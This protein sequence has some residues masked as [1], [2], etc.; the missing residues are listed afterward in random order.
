MN[1]G[2]EEVTEQRKEI[3][4]S[5]NVEYTKMHNK[6][7]KYVNCPKKTLK[8]SREF[9]CKPRGT[10]LINPLRSDGSQ[11]SDGRLDL[12]SSSQRHSKL[13]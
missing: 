8:R 6:E 10:V 2:T 4:A 5:Q 12:E 13:S 7:V 3:E 1:S 11:K 9:Y